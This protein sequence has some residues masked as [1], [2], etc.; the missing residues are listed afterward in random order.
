MII[1]EI[2]LDFLFNVY[3][4]ICLSYYQTSQINLEC[5]RVERELRDHI[6][7]KMIQVLYF[8]IILLGSP[9]RMSLCLSSI[10]GDSSSFFFPE[11]ESRESIT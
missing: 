7:S 2:Y 10:C 1:L 11:R 9:N 5:Q 4:S 3:Y 6:S 8:F